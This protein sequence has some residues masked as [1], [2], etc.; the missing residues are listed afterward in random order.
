[1]FDKD[2][3]AVISSP[4]GQ[5]AISIIRVSGDKTHNAVEKIFRPKLKQKKYSDLKINKN[6]L[7]IIQHK[8]EIIDEVIISKLKKP[9]SFT[10]EDMVEIFCHGSTYI[11]NRIMEL[12]SDRGIRTAKPGEFSLRSYVNG[13]MDLI[14]AEG[15]SD[16]ISS[17][18]KASHKL[19]MNQV[20]GGVSNEIKKMRDELLNLSSLIELELDFSEEDVEFASRDKF[21]SLLNNVE[22]FISELVDSFKYGNAMKDGIPVS[23]VGSPNVG[24]STLLNSILNEDKAITSPIS[25]TTRDI[26]EDTFNIEGKL[27]RFIDTAGI[28]KTEDEIEKIGISRTLESINRSEIILYLI[29]L[30]SSDKNIDF[31]INESN[32]LKKKYKEKSIMLIFTKADLVKKQIKKTSL[33]KMLI[34]TKEKKDVTYLK[35]KIIENLNQNFSNKLIITNSRHYS[36][37]SLAKKE[38]N[39]VKKG[40]KNNV[41]SDLLT[42]DLKQVLYHLG[43]V[44]GEVTNEDIL[45]NIFSKFC[46]G[47]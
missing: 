37:L 42:I 5:G 45:S 4:Q 19:A 1:M 41:P 18:S 14:Q 39:N 20:R 22:E 30:T 8:D 43:E 35:S 6:Y 21:L 38:I 17:N 13:K 15:I 36:A 47:K 34:N 46:I 10:G 29:D 24:K 28:R 11:Q 25:G 7:G 23:I 16:L 26:I 12:L 40:L 33:K 9:N 3:I 2:T 32:K 31:E 27:F 44:T